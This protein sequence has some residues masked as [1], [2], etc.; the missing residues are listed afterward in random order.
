MQHRH[1]DN[2]GL[3]P[4]AIDDIMEKG[5]LADWVALREACA[6][7]GALRAVAYRIALARTDAPAEDAWSMRHACWRNH[8][9]LEY[10]FSPAHEA[11]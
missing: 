6:R 8:L 10:G 1:L 4:A 3:S 2:P 7:E 9:E 11:A 5:S